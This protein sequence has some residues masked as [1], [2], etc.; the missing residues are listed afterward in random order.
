MPLSSSSMVDTSGV[1][2]VEG[3]PPLNRSPQEP[4]EPSLWASAAAD[5]DLS[6]SPPWY[7]VVDGDS[8]AGSEG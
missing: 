6:E 1:G 4:M 8:V 3:V 7:E 2:S 5:L